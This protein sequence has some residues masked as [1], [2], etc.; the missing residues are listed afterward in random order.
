MNNCAVKP[1]LTSYQVGY[2]IAIPQL[3]CCCAHHPV[4]SPIEELICIFVR[5]DGN[6]WKPVALDSTKYSKIRAGQQIK[7]FNSVQYVTIVGFENSIS[8]TQNKTKTC[9]RHTRSRC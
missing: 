2:K 3:L 6:F 5:V 9:T 4:I 1:I 8:V 7:V